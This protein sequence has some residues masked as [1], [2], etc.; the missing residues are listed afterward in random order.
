[1]ECI[2]MQVQRS[3]FFVR[4]FFLEC[5]DTIIKGR[6]H[7]QSGLSGRGSN[8]VDDYLVA[9]Q[10]LAFPVHADEGEELVFDRVPFARAGWEVAYR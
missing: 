10:Y 9:R 5:I 3:H 6:V 7:L 4:H 2:G 1:M 8:E